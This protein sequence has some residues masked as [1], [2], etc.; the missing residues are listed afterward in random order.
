MAARC[1]S[2]DLPMMTTPDEPRPV[3]VDF[4]TLGDLL[5]GWLEQ[6]AGSRTGSSGASRSGSRTGSSGARRTTTGSGP[7]AEWRPEEPLLNQAFVYRRSQIVAAAE[8]GEGSVG[9]GISAA[10]AV[11][12][13]IFGGWAGGRRVRLLGARLRLRVGVRVP[14]GRADGDPA[15][16]AADPADRE[17]R[18]SGRE[19]VAAA[20]GDDP[21]RAAADLLLVRE[22][23]IRIVGDA[24]ATTTSTGSTW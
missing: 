10:E 9:G 1:C 12:P 3:V 16:V 8:D 4:P 19:R 21:P 5:D 14:A 2:E 7:E 13:V 6:H 17:Q 18:G 24:R 15:S 22:D 23:F 20:D 11:G